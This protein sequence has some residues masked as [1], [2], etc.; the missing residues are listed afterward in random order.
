MFLELS[1]LVPNF[2][3]KTAAACHELFNNIALILSQSFFLKQ[4]SILEQEV[5]SIDD[6]Q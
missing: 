2:G 4:E 1:F 6:E 5:T 3:F